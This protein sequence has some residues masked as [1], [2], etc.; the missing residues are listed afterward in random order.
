MRMFFPLLELSYL[1]DRN[2]SAWTKESENNLEKFNFF[3]APPGPLLRTGTTEPKESR[4]VHEPKCHPTQC[5]TIDQ[6]PMALMRLRRSP[7]RHWFDQKGELEWI[8]HF[9]M[10]VN[11]FKLAYWERDLHHNICLAF[12][13]FHN[14]TV[15]TSSLRLPLWSYLQLSTDKPFKPKRLE[16]SGTGINP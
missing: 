8:P 11:N 6:R 14:K 2:K 5:T 3:I 15:I 1:N 16:R 10:S 7:S 9:N 12:L 4:L 13:R